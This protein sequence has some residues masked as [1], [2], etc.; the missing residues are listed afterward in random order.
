[1]DMPR[2]VGAFRKAGFRV[3]PYPVDYT[4]SRIT[5]FDLEPTVVG[6]LG[7]LDHAAHEWFGLLAYRFLRCTDTL[8]PGP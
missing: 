1:M 3:L 2:A 7:R 4:T 5:T 6:N 8:F